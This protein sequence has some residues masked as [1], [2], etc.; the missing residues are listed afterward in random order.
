MELGR[1]WDKSGLNQAKLL[2]VGVTLDAFFTGLVPGNPDYG[3][4]RERYLYDLAI[5][6]SN[7]HMAL[8]CDVVIGGLVSQYLHAHLDQ[9]KS[10]LAALD[11]F[12]EGAAASTCAGSTANPTAAAQLSTMC[13]PSLTRFEST[14]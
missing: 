9:L 10:R 3:A 14:F 13:A 2:G 6:V 1:F 8:D 4:I 7:I 12:G 11:V 5:G